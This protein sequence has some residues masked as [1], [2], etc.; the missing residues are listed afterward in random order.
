MTPESLSYIFIGIVLVII[1]LSTPSVDLC[2]KDNEVKGGW[3]IL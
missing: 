3:G 2:S 1:S